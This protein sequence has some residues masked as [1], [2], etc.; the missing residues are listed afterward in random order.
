MAGRTSTNFNARDRETQLLGSAIWHIA[1]VA[2]SWTPPGAGAV[3]RRIPGQLERVR[4]ARGDRLGA[5]PNDH[6]PDDRKRQLLLRPTATR[7]GRRPAVYGD[8]PALYARPT[9]RT[10]TRTER[11]LGPDPPDRRPEQHAQTSSSPR[12]TRCSTSTS[13]CKYIALDN[14]LANHETGI[15]NGARRRL[16]P[17]PRRGRHAVQARAARPRLDHGDGERTELTRPARSSGSGPRTASQTVRADRG[18]QNFYQGSPRPD[19]LVL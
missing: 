1:G 8:G 5:S 12:R 10:R 18:M 7:A 3:Q 9:L 17:V 16:R 13:G 19:Q 6:F 15:G 2:A 4:A 14:L 11:L